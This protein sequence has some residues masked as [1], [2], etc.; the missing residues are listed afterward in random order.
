MPKVSP[1]FCQEKSC[2]MRLLASDGPHKTCRAC[3]VSKKFPQSASQPRP[4]ISEVRAFLK[5]PNDQALKVVNEICMMRGL[6][7]VHL[8]KVQV[9]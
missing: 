6:M 7:K 1:K 8:K 4:R 5:I 3:R 2:R 9:G